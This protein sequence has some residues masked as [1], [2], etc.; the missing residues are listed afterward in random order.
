VH[1]TAAHDLPA[2]AKAIK[3]ISVVL[4]AVLKT[5]IQFQLVWHSSK[6]AEQD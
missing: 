5:L 1:L 4:L 3:A 2:G 6:T